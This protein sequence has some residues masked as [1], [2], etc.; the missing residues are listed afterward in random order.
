VLSVVAESLKTKP[1]IRGKWL[2]ENL[3]AAPVPPPPPNVTANLDADPSAKTAS[4]REMLEA[5]R[6]NPVCA[7]CHARMDPMGFSLENFDALG[8]W[9]TMDAG[10]PI[11]AAGVLLDGSTVEGPAAL[12]RALTG[13]P[14]QFVK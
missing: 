3:L 2:L 8:Q 9:R 11:N 10:E 1:T 12:R 4:V 5:H 6:K 7:S 13:Q 14:E